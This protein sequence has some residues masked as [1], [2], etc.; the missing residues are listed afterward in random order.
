[1]KGNENC[2]TDYGWK[3]LE[4]NPSVG[5]GTKLKFISEK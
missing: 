5:K 2:I 1:M 3:T 4:T